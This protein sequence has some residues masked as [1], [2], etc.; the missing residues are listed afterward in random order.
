MSPR[1]GEQRGAA[2]VSVLM[3]AAAGMYL[4]VRSWTAV[5]VV[6]APPVTPTPSGGLGQVP[7]VAE[8]QA[9]D[10]VLSRVET[11]E[12]DPFRA[13][14]TT[15]RRPVRNTP[16]PPAEEPPPALSMVLYDQ[17]SPEVQFSVDGAYSGRLKVGQSFRGW[18][19]MSISSRS[20]VVAKNGKT[21]TLS[22]RR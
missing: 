18:T 20:C 4:L 6:M 16:P 8:A 19:V 15:F 17:V 12:R 7:L 9:R 11:P 10:E 13:A 22:S 2:T 21:F 3:L 5:H 14:R 1:V